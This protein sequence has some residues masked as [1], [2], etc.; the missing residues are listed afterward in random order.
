MR[1]EITID[2]AGSADA[3]YVAW[4]PVQSS[5]RIIEP[6]DDVDFVDVVLRNQHEDRGGQIVFL[7]T[8]PGEG[9]DRLRIR[10]S[11]DGTPLD[12][13][14][15]GKPGRPS[16][17]DKDAVLE[18]VEA[19]TEVVL[20]TRALMVRVRKNANDLTAGERDRFLSAF[21]K[22]NNQGMGRFRDFR[23]M[24]RDDTSLEAHGR[25]GFLP[26]HRAYLLDLE[27]ELQRID[28]SVALPYWKFDEPAPN[29][30]TRAF[31]GVPNI[32]G[33]VQFD[34]GNPLE[35][36]ATDGAVAGIERSPRFDTNTSGA[37]VI[38]EE[39]TLLLGGPG[40]RYEGF[41]D[42]EGD[43]H[44]RAHTSFRGSISRID[45]AAK[46]PLFFLLHANVDRLW[47][48]WQWL[49]GRFDAADLATYPFLGSAGGPGAT[50]RIGHNLRDTMWPWNQETNP[51]RPP[52]APG[53][54]F[55]P[56][57]TE[58]APGLVPMVG[59]MI[60]Y[61]GTFDLGD[62]LGFDYD[63]SPSLIVEHRR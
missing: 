55:P 4:A 57:P 3:S 43:P 52:T 45:T 2:G 35:F 33:R 38:G 18:T 26:W 15:A 56:S 37:F 58:N 36:W 24:H 59:D 28:P 5:I 27:R 49:N 1:T 8:I 16:Q 54:D 62:R 21:A 50:T 44:G 17:Q 11:A 53:G 31:I 41:M 22:L 12:F 6:D 40:N 39:D 23:D 51:P 10:L 9:K 42:M 47:A 61:Q 19:D 60:D 63:D 25:A 7:D 48:K 29:L 32:L 46:D 34:P 14:I 13:F 20:S 30:F